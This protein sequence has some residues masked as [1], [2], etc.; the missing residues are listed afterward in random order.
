MLPI[1]VELNGSPWYLLRPLTVTRGNA[2]FSI[3]DTMEGP[4]LSV[5][6][7]E[8]ITLSAKAIPRGVPYFAVSPQN[9]THPPR[10]E[11]VLPYLVFLNAS[12]NATD[13]KFFYGAIG[14]DSESTDLITEIHVSGGLRNGWQEIYGEASYVRY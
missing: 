9:L 12:S 8:S 2:T 4:M 3:V 7:N 1:P 11:G 13:F 6:S 14:W 5:E 10:R